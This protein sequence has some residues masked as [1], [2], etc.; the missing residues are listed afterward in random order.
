VR[1]RDFKPIVLPFLSDL[2]VPFTNNLDE[3]D[4]RMMKVK[5]ET[6][7]CFRSDAGSADFVVIRTHRDRQESVVGMFWKPSPATRSA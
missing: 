3:Q 7:G 5:Q 2:S 1:L 4:V 6:S